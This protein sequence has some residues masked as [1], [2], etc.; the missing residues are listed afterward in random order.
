VIGRWMVNAQGWCHRHGVPY[1]HGCVWDRECRSF[2]APLRVALMLGRMMLWV[3]L[4]GYYRDLTGDC[5]S[6]HGVSFGHYR[7]PA[8]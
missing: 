6:W 7:R 5:R 4:P 2:G 1:V 8:G 3:D